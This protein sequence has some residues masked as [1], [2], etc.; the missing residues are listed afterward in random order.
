MVSPPRPI[1]SPTLLA[2]ISISCTAPPPSPSPWKPGPF[3]H[4]STIW[5]SSRFACL[6]RTRTVTELG[7]Q[8]PEPDEPVLVGPGQSADTH[9][10]LSGVPV[11]E[12]GRS[13]SPPLSETQSSHQRVRTGS[14]PGPGPIPDSPEAI[15]ILHPDS[16]WILVICSPP[17]PITEEQQAER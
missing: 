15:W 8:E 1:T 17:L 4:R 5:T 12:H 9:S 14:E 11:S 13:I 7:P 2:G 10:M 6:D 16:S 3:R